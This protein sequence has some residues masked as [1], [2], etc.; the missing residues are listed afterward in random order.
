MSIR[1]A[2]KFVATLAVSAIS[3]QGCDVLLLGFFYEDVGLALPDLPPKV[4]KQEHSTDWKNHVEYT[5]RTHEDGSI[6]YIAENE[7][8]RQ[9]TRI[10]VDKKGKEM[11]KRVVGAPIKNVASRWASA[12]DVFASLIK[13]K[14]VPALVQP[15]ET[16]PKRHEP[17][18]GGK[19]GGE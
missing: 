17:K 14:P 9:Y 1:I 4:V 10:R 7:D 13:T 19:S 16:P 8:T 5:K 12:G 2:L 11:S 3:L 6:T 18:G 15:T